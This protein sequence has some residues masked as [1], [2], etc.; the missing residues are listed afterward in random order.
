MT[1]RTQTLSNMVTMVTVSFDLKH[2]FKIFLN[3]GYFNKG[4]TDY[5]KSFNLQ[6]INQ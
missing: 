2:F 1:G 4:F 3:N 5:L 6:S